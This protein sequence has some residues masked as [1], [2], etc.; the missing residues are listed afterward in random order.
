MRTTAGARLKRL[1][2]LNDLQMAPLALP[3]M[4]V[5]ENSFVYSD[6]STEARKVRLVHEWVERS[7]SRPPAA[8]P[9]TLFPE[10]GGTLATL[11]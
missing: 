10:D 5:G 8:P 3:G 2:I 11:C 4:A 6:E 9:G 1:A 7:L